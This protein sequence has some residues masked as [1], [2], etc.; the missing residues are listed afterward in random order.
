MT[1]IF[2]LKYIIMKKSV[3]LLSF[4]LL[5]MSTPISVVA[6]KIYTEDSIELKK[7]IYKVSVIT[8]DLKKSTGYL[9]D[10]SD[11]NLYL[12]PSP[13]P[14]SS[15]KIN[16]HLSYY[17]YDHLEKIE[18]KRKTA[19]ARGAWQGALIGLAAGVIAGLVSGDDP[20][21][22]TYNDPN[23]PL[24]SA[25][26]N[27]YSSISN[28]FRKSAAEKAVTLGIIGEGTGGLIGA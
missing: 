7:R 21:A 9:A 8:T 25:L 3:T 20:V 14:F 26:G 19:A 12:F 22:P 2:N 1:K 27:V 23:D 6:Q 5:G 16:D 17:P 18:I 10:L 11:S 4:C 13:L 24:G 15:V 28:A